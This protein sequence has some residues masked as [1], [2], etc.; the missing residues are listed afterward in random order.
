MPLGVLPVTFSVPRR[1][2]TGFLK[3]DKRKPLSFKEQMMYKK[4][5]SSKLEAFFLS[6]C[7]IFFAMCWEL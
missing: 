2:L 3:P 4:I 5:F 6:C 1:E 7:E